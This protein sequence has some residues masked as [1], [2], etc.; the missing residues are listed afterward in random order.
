MS[1]LRPDIHQLARLVVPR[2]AGIL[3]RN[4]VRLPFPLR[5]TYMLILRRLLPSLRGC[6]SPSCY[7]SR[8][9]GWDGAAYPWGGP[10]VSAWARLRNDYRK[11]VIEHGSEGHAIETDITAFYEHIM[12]TEFVEVLAAVLGERAGA[13]DDELRALD[14]LLQT[15]TFKGRGL[16]QNMDPSRFLADAYLRVIDDRVRAIADVNYLRFVDDI[17]VVAR[18]RGAA[19]RG[20]QQLEVHL[21]ANGLFLNSK[22][23][24][25]IDAK[26]A[27]WEKTKDATHDFR[28]SECDELLRGA[29]EEGVRETLRVATHEMRAAFARHD[30]GLVRA[31]GN[32]VVRAARFRAVQTTA[33]VELEAIAIEGFRLFPGDA[34]S[35]T[36]FAA[37]GLSQQGAG[38]LLGILEAPAYNAHPWTNMWLVIAMARAPSLSG[39]AM[40]KLRVIVANP[41]EPDYL[42]GWAAVAFARH[43]DGLQRREVVDACLADPNSMFLRRAAV[44][45]AQELP[46][47]T[48]S[49]LRTQTT[50]RD[51]VLSLL[52][53]YTDQHAVYDWYVPELLEFART[54]A[55]PEEAPFFEAIGLV[56]GQPRT[57]KAYSRG[58]EYEA[59]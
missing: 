9:E 40:D 19:I 12:I 21:K 2:D 59:G 52:W 45:A 43:G 32:R 58:N 16:V 33:C 18:T 46:S 30:A 37:P 14:E 56:D 1:C 44:V 4:T 24:L 50:G 22:K 15:G 20:L 36:E 34:E 53:E 13:F 42:R 8:L 5:V 7:S 35:W 27:E 3:S 6:V 47:A 54:G 10:R 41:S 25:M 51:P 26:G 49:A 28:L 38:E 17:R 23:T 48:K 55:K 29:T 31:Y 11:L 57:F 39:S